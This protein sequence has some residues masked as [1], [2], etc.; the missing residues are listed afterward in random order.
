MEGVP[1]D[2]D[3][4]LPSLEAIGAEEQPRGVEV[5]VEDEEK[6]VEASLESVFCVGSQS[7]AA[8]RA[9]R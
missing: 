3:Q 4:H 1:G 7:R 6:T 9:P 8:A 2:G 5:V